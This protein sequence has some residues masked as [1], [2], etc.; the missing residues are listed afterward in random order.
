MKLNLSILFLFLFSWSLTAQTLKALIVDGQN[1]HQM[2]PKTT[3]MMKQYLEETGLFEVDVQRTAF[4]WKGKEYLLKFKLK[5]IETLAKEKPQADPKFKPKF[6]KYD[7]VISNFGW[8]AADWPASTQK[9]IG[10]IRKKRG[11]I[12]NCTRR[13]QLFSQV[14]GIQQNDWSGRLG[15]P[16]GK[17]WSLCLL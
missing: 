16:H 10:E 6:K 11:R 17:R 13:E 8:N 15:R 2:W 3:M 5:G 4:T 1:N 7:V 12:S 9:K 14:V